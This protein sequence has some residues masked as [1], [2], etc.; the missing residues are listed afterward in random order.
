MPGVIEKL[1]ELAVKSWQAVD[2][3]ALSPCGRGHGSK[4]PVFG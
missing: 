1:L 4:T 2:Y 3:F